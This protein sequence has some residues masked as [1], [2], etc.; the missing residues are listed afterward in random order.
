[1]RKLVLAISGIA[2][3]VIFISSCGKK[4]VFSEY[5]SIDAEKGWAKDNRIS[6]DVNID[7]TISRYN[8]YVNVR[9]GDVYQFRNLFVFLVT[10]Y[11]DGRKV[12]DTLECLLADDKN[13]W[14][15]EG[16]G[17]LWDNTIPF[18][19]NAKFP[20]KGKYKFTYEQAMRVDPLPMIKDM[21]L[22]IDKAE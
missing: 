9:Q 6:F 4:S 11:P 5:K 10:E 7:D 19:G 21:G 8:V 16:A 2:L 22:T 15:G 20:V 17:D 12:K 18:K 13:Q 3:S 14:M 1:M